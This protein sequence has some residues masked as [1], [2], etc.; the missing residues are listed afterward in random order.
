MFFTFFAFVLS[1]CATYQGKISSARTLMLLGRP[2]EAAKSLQK[3]AMTPGD[4]QLVYLLDYATFLQQAGDYDE[5]TKAFLKAADIAEIKDYH[6]LSRIAGSLIFSEEMVQYKGEDYEKLMIHIMLAINFVMKRDFDGA[7]VE[8][9]RLDNK[10]HKYRM[11]A[12]RDYEQNPFARYLSGMIWEEDK[13]WDDAYIDYEHTFE[14][15]P[16]I[17]MI[18]ADLI[19]SSERAQRRKKNREWRER[20]SEVKLNRWWTKKN[21]GELVL[22]YLQG[23]AP[24]KKPH[25]ASH[26]IPKL[27]A[28]SSDTRFARVSVDGTP[29]ATSETI[30]S[31]QDVAIKTL[32]DA[33]AGL[34]AKRV[35][36]VVAKKVLADKISEKNELLGAIAW[37]GLNITDRADLRQW[38]TLPESIQVARIPLVE[39]EHKIS[40]EGL[41]MSKHLTSQPVVE[42]IVKI[43]RGRKT[44]LLW[45]TF[46]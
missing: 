34:I 22:L 20:F 25:P 3:L 30:Y 29:A 23:R 6:S 45:Q 38:S 21:H 43:E 1:G 42:K 37:I 7:M 9:R 17:E 5:S 27:Y 18:K 36:G 4:D 11:E 32:D 26:R 31:V 41:G 12:K 10:L 13:K 24:V 35:G 16:G 15:R 46:E 8:V 33:Y 44:F 28:V 19:R 40:L 39:G 14:L 2:G